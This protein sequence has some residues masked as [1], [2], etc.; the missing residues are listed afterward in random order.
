MVIFYDFTIIF[1]IF[2]KKS[3]GEESFSLIP[4]VLVVILMAMRD[5]PNGN[6]T[7][8]AVYSLTLVVKA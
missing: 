8:T 4:P 2:T 3:T 7:R 6:M 5:G 1:E